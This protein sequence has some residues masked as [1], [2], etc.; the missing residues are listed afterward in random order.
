MKTRT[1]QME[2]VTELAPSADWYIGPDQILVWR[3]DVAI[4]PSESAIQEK[5]AELKAEFSALEYARNRKTE[6][7]KLNQLE[8]QFDFVDCGFP[9]IPLIKLHFKLI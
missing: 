8:M 2:A 1:F 4:K 5:M 7:D 3:D 9:S 6:Y